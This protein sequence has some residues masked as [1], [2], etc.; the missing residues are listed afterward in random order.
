MTAKDRKEDFE[1]AM[2]VDIAAK[3]DALE[4]AGF[5]T[6]PASTKYHGNYE[7][8]LYDH[9]RQVMIELVS[10]TAKL[11][12]MWSR[13]ESPLIVGMF[14][15]LCKADAYIKTPDGWAHDPDPFLTEH[16]AKS[17]ILTQMY[18]TRLTREEIY[19][20]RYHMGPFGRRGADDE[21]AKEFNRAI[22]KFENVLFTHTAD[23]IPSQIFDT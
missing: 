10:L 13:P 7:G 17:V 11:G 19:C 16:G 8:G 5:F 9:S 21:E 15:D 1:R 22:K 2:P 20:I 3:A 12:L 14:H 23:K 6:A 4:I 18:V